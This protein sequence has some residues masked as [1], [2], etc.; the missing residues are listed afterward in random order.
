MTW[1]YGHE[2]DHHDETPLALRGDLQFFPIQHQGQ[3]LILV[4]DDLGL[5]QE[6]QAVPLSLY[7]FMALL[8]GTRS[9]RE[10]QAE[11]M[12]QQGGLLVGTSEVDRLLAHLDTSFLLDSH[13]YQKARAE[14]VS[15]FSSQTVRPAVH[16][17]QSYPEDPAELGFRLDDIMGKGASGV[18][19]KGR[20][21]SLVAP[22]IDLSVGEKAYASTYQVLKQRREH[23]RRQNKP[24]RV[25]ILGTGHQLQQGLFSLTTKDFETPLGVTPTEDEAVHRLAEAGKGITA[26]DDFVHRSEH[27]IEFQLIFLQHLLED[28]P[29]TLIPVLCGNLQTGLREYTRSA[30][31]QAAGPFLDCLKTLLNDTEQDTLLVAG[32]DLSHTGPKFG[33]DMP[34]SHLQSEFESHDRALLAHLAEPDAD[35]FWEESRRVE[36]RFNVCGFSALA[37]LLEILP[38]CTGETRHYEVWHEEATRSAVSFASVVFTI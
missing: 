32:V 28:I 2:M 8:D 27:S 21:I 30:Y 22:H 5:V 14:L 15:R 25:I 37:C 24:L 38:P 3:Q 31:Q 10:L 12:R 35:L 36:D 13:R 1:S 20:L 9:R 6:G 34:A 23:I 19:S 29:F 18:P 7:R 17:G 11:M 33:H 4:K 26:P 16:S